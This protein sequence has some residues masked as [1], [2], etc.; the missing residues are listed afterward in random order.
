MVL[1]FEGSKL[2]VGISIPTMSMVVVILIDVDVQDWNRTTTI[3]R[4]HAPTRT[5]WRMII[6]L[7]YLKRLDPGGFFLGNF[8]LGDCF[9]GS[10]SSA[11]PF[12]AFF[13]SSQAC[14]KTQAFAVNLPCFL[15]DIGLFLFF[16]GNFSSAEAVT[17]KSASNASAFAVSF[18]L[19]FFLHEFW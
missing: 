9:L 4:T 6:P 15:C 10:S 17:R 5:A 1:S 16:L 18:S 13:S 3:L 14:K 11:S 7:P 12:S 2:G 8:L 19:C